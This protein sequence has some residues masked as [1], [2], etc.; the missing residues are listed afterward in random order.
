MWS[1]D[2]IQIVNFKA[3]PSLIASLKE[4]ISDL[5]R[6]SPHHSG[7]SGKITKVGDLYKVAISVEC[8]TH[9]I[10]QNAESSNVYEAVYFVFQAAFAKLI[11]QERSKIQALPTK[12]LGAPS[13]NVALKKYVS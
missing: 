7:F 1:V 8:G 5:Q 6:A 3:Q 12:K 11:E 9:L 13:K 10:E 2:A 4:F